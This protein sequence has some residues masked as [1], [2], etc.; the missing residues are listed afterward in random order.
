LKYITTLQGPISTDHPDHK[1]F[2]VIEN[3]GYKN[4]ELITQ[5]LKAKEKDNPVTSAI[6]AE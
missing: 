1:D 2:N 6:H 4:G 5:P 3:E